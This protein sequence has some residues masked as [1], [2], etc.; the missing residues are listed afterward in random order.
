MFRNPKTPSGGRS[1]IHLPLLSPRGGGAEP[2]SDA[3]ILFELAGEN[4]ANLLFGRFGPEEIRSR[5]GRAGILTAL[6]GRGYPDPLVVLECADPAEQRLFLYADR[7]A[8][9]RLLVEV[10]IEL[11][12]F[13]PKRPIG[14]FTEE[15][16]LR[17]L[18]IQWILLADPDRDFS[19][20]RP[21]LPGQDRPGLGLLSPFLSLL[22]EF[23]RE[24]GQDGVLDVPH[25]YHAALFY[26]AMFR[27]LDPE[28]EGR[29]LAMRRDLRGVPLA[30]ASE[31][32][33][34]E[35][36]RD[37]ATGGPVPWTPAEQVLPV[38]SALR[39]YFRSEWYRAHRDRAFAAARF[40]V[41][42]DAY[43]ARLAKKGPSGKSP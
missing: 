16:A 41:D 39:R 4:P 10:R 18:I 13:R 27:F 23:A 21:R 34:D 14:P 17:M 3:E 36:L 2:P 28:V 30:L 37:A 6:A 15:S 43:R 11:R 38:R 24:M 5:L 32:V 22:K 35:C 29:F 12:G 42:W 8:R 20:A 1:R 40:L 25:H 19:P 31:A 9:D 33:E 26:S 7:P